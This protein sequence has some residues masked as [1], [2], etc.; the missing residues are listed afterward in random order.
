MRLPQRE[1]A[2]R[3][4]LA[5][6]FQRLAKERERTGFFPPGLAG[7]GAE[8]AENGGGERRE[9]SPRRRELTRGAP[10]ADPGSARR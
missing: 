9:F 1:G 3:L 8:G 7:V 10:G 6:V 2:L 4:D 5:N